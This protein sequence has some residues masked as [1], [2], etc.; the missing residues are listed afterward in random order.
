[1][2]ILN[3]SSRSSFF[4]AGEGGGAIRP[5]TIR[6]AGW[7]RPMASSFSRQRA[8]HSGKLRLRHIT[9]KR[10]LFEGVFE[11]VS[12]KS[13]CIFSKSDLVGGGFH[14]VP[15]QQKR[16]RIPV[17]DPSL[18]NY[19]RREAAALHHLQRIGIKIRPSTVRV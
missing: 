19:C 6:S 8:C 14:C 13:G 5:S 3:R 2:L 9:P 15:S 1:M 4:H 11:S 7:T 16:I 18:R 12:S 10:S 17:V